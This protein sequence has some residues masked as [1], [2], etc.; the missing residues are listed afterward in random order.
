[1]KAILLVALEWFIAYNYAA[2]PINK[3]F[4]SNVKYY[5]N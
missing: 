3:S 2:I 1:M 5:K 4:D